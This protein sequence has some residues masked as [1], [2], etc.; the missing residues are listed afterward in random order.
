MAI[1]IRSVLYLFKRLNLNAPI[2]HSF[3]KTFY[4]M[5]SKSKSKMIK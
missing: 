1:K 5:I 4:K 2:N 3:K